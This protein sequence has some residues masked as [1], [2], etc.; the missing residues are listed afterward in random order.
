MST[1]HAGS[2]ISAHSVPS[3]R[4]ATRSSGSRRGRACRARPAAGGRFRLWPPDISW[5]GTWSLFTRRPSAKMLRPPDQGSA[6]LPP[7]SDPPAVRVRV[8]LA[9][10]SGKLEGR[11]PTEGR[12][13]FL[14]T[15][16]WRCPAGSSPFGPR[17]SLAPSIAVS[18]V[19]ASP[20]PRRRMGT[21]S[22][23][24]GL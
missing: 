17:P 24:S 20:S 3:S 22:V 14:S 1:R 12:V 19:R 23:G 15:L 16:K 21:F 18:V 2:A 13:R 6:G 7:I 10:L 8:G 4:R 5:F 9:P 11:E